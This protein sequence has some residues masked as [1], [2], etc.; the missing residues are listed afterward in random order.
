MVLVIFTISSST[1][2][3]AI[4]PSVLWTYHLY[5]HQGL[6]TSLLSSQGIDLPT[7]PE[8]DCMA[9]IGAEFCFPSTAPHGEVPFEALA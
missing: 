5:D 1:Y 7:F 3:N 8:S 4:N 9:F 2:M 6:R